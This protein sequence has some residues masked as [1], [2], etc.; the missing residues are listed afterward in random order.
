M[1]VFIS[2]IGEIG[3]IRVIGFIGATGSPH[4]ITLIAL[5]TPIYNKA[6]QHLKKKQATLA[7]GLHN[8]LHY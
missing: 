1:G 3:V 6:Q 5:I 2:D 7:D 4:P 8:Y